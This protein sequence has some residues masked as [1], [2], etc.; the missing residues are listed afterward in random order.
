MLKEQRRVLGRAEIGTRVG[1]ADLA[2]R[3]LKI[4]L[5]YTQVPSGA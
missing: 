4:A 5:E 1:A 2:H 3:I